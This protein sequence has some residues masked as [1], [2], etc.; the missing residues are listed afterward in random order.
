MAINY[1]EGYESAELKDY[2]QTLQGQS[3][4]KFVHE[5]CFNFSDLKVMD[6]RPSEK[7]VKFCSQEGIYTLK[8]KVRSTTNNK[9]ETVDEYVVYTP[10]YSKSRGRTWADRRT[11]SSMKLSSL[12]ANMKRNSVL[13]KSVVKMAPLNSVVQNLRSNI[14]NSVTKNH[15]SNYKSS[16]SVDAEAHHAM[17]KILLDGGSPDLLLRFDQTKLRAVLNHFN[18]VDKRNAEIQEIVDSRLYNGSLF[19]IGIC[20]ETDDYIVAKFKLDKSVEKEVVLESMKRVKSITQSYSEYVP[21]LTM[22]KV[23]YE[24]KRREWSMVDNAE[25]WPI[26]GNDRFVADFDANYVEVSVGDNTISWLI[27]PCSA[28]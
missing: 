20:R 18:E 3:L 26:F 19:G 2:F 10:W 12:I 5:L 13:P 27:A 7:W 8:A 11:L 22:L 6:F 28:I 14:S 17:L 9:N 1:Y 25:D 23:A 24:N 16:S 21:Y 15:Q 4:S